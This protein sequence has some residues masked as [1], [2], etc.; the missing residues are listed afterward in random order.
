[1]ALRANYWEFV[2]YK[3][4]EFP[5]AGYYEVPADWRERLPRKRSRPAELLRTNLEHASTILDVGAGNRSYKDV[6]ASI[7]IKGSYKSVD[8]DAMFP[9]DYTDFMQVRDRFDAILML[10]LLEHLPLDV[11]LEFIEHAREL[12]NPGGI[13]VVSTPNPHHPNHVWRIELTHVRPWPAPDLFAALRLSGFKN[14]E[15]YRQYIMFSP[16]RKFILPIEKLLYRILELDHA[17]G[18][19]G[20]ART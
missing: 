20:F 14:V 11:G 10:E 8:T 1:V 7:G 15:V 4:A 2:Q 17:Q 18:L 3:D 12:L 9:H 19:V 6:L 16:R 5:G 13:L